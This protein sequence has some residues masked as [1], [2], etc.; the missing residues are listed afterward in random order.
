MEAVLLK[1]FTINFIGTC[2]AIGV[3]MTTVKRVAGE[4]SLRPWWK[5]YVN[6]LLPLC[7]SS[8]VAFIPQVLPGAKYGERWMWGVVA[9][10]FS[11]IIYNIIQKKFD[12]ENQILPSSVEDVTDAQE[13]IKEKVEFPEEKKPEPT[14]PKPLNDDDKTPVLIKHSDL[15]AP[16]VKTPEVKKDDNK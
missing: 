4:Y 7:L 16:K 13:E 3:I 5:R 10:L 6:P 8:G 15:N 11:H 2:I 14:D 1:I 12:S 9:T